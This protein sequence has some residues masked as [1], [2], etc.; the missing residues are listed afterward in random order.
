M[1][2]CSWGAFKYYVSTIRGVGGLNLGKTCLGNIW[3]LPWLLARV[4]SLDSEYLNFMTSVHDYNAIILYWSTMTDIFDVFILKN[5]P[6]KSCARVTM[7]YLTAD[8]APG[9]FTGKCLAVT[10]PG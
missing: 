6:T 3:T 4:M 10:I 5:S 2:S 9:A 7:T 8:T 1:Y